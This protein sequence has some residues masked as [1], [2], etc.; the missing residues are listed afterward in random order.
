V[1]AFPR[2]TGLW[3]LSAI[4]L[5]IGVAGVVVQLQRGQH[6]GAVLLAAWIVVVGGGL[7]SISLLRRRLRP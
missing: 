5:V 1:E 4:T 6:T 7:V 3:I 2:F